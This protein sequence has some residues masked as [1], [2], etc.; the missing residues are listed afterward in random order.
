[1]DSVKVLKVQFEALPLAERR[2]PP[3][4]L[5]TRQPSSKYFDNDGVQPDSVAQSVLLT[6]IRKRRWRLRLTCCGVGDIYQAVAVYCLEEGCD[7]DAWR[8]WYVTNAIRKVYRE[9]QKQRRVEALYAD[10]ADCRTPRC[11]GSLG[12]LEWWEVRRK[13]VGLTGRYVRKHYPRLLQVDFLHRRRG[14]PLDEAI[15]EG[16]YGRTA[17]FQDKKKALQFAGAQLERLTA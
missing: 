17:Y 3:T 10:G 7:F 6:F 16:G 1:M 8:P 13:V 4:E 2:D 15:A 5:E 9:S 12:E 11:D 14:L